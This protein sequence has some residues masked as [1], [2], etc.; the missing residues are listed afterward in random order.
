MSVIPLTNNM[1]RVAKNVRNCM[2]QFGVISISIII[3][4]SDHIYIYK[5]IRL[6]KLKPILNH[7]IPDR[8]CGIL[9]FTNTYF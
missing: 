8:H 7:H 3:Y 5:L 4:K 2:C 9:V 1:M 6:F